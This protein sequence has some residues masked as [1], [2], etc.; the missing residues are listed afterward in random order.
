MLR[1]VAHLDEAFG[2][3]FAGPETMRRCKDDLTELLNQ[4]LDNPLVVKIHWLWNRF[5]AILLAVLGTISVLRAE[6]LMGSPFVIG[7]RNTFFLYPWHSD[8]PQDAINV[9]TRGSRPLSDDKSAASVCNQLYQSLLVSALFAAWLL[10]LLSEMKRVLVGPKFQIDLPNCLH[11]PP[12]QDRL[13]HR[14]WTTRPACSGAWCTNALKFVSYLFIDYALTF[15]FI[16]AI[17]MALAVWASGRLTISGR[18]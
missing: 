15:C 11:E 9:V 17:W 18:V 4:D 7:L 10:A 6:V 5:I 12:T 16:L 13:S 2:K 1:F 8:D 3:I 14:F